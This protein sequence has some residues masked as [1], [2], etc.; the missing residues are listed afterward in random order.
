MWLSPLFA[1]PGR[2]RLPLFADEPAVD[3]AAVVVVNAGKSQVSSPAPATTLN[4]ARGV[5]RIGRP[6]CAPTKG[7]ANGGAEAEHGTLAERD[8]E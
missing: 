6:C 4:D 8:K 3:E 7:F 5:V 1:V 2:A